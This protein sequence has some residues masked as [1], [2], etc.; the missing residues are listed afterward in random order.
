MEVRLTANGTIYYSDN[1]DVHDVI[2]T[3]AEKHNEWLNEDYRNYALAEINGIKHYI[4]GGLIN[5]WLK[6]KITIDQF[7]EFAK[8]KKLMLS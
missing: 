5:W 3:L 4:T 7:A 6:G 2:D 1:A 8:N